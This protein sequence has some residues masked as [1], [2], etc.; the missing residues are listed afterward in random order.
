MA[1]RAA[2]DQ[3]TETELVVRVRDL[4]LPRRAAGAITPTGRDG[5]EFVDDR[6]SGLAD[7]SSVVEATVVAADLAYDIQE[8]T[9]SDLLATGRLDPETV[10][11]E[12]PGYI[13]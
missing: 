2:G 7:V 11:R 6:R 12:L 8:Q 4:P 1:S 3:V 9:R 5:S 13:I 10:S